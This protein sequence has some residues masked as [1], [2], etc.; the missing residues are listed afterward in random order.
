[1]RTSLVTLAACGFL[2]S[3]GHAQPYGTPAS[4][5]APL[6]T[7]TAPVIPK[8][9]QAAYYAGLNRRVL[10]SNSQFELLNQLAQEHRKRADETPRDQAAKTQWESDL[11]KELGE[12]AAATLNLVNNATKE[13][14]AFEQNHPDLAALVTAISFN[15]STNGPHPATITFLEKLAEKRAALQQEIAAS[16]EA[17]SLY[18]VQM[19]TNNN[20]SDPNRVPYLIQDNAVYLKQLQKDLFDLDLKS[21]EF[22][23]LCTR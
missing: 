6:S 20:A 7:N 19:A 11:A 2:V 18:A 16:T 23:A 15:A 21:L 9:D 3:I 17:A 22:R 10:E 12:R 1:M 14:L 4:I 8:T 5:N 13:R